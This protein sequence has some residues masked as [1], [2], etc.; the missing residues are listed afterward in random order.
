M[1]FSQKFAKINIMQKETKE[2][3]KKRIT[4]LF[5]STLLILF[6]ISLTIGGFFF[7]RSPSKQNQKEKITK[8]EAE[9][10]IKSLSPYLLLRETPQGK[11]IENTKEGISLKVP[12][13]WEVNEAISEQILEIRKFGPEQTIETELVDGTVLKLYA[14]ENPEGLSIKEIIMKNWGYIPKET[15]I[16]E[17]NG[18]EIAK[19]EDK[20]VIG[21]NNQKEED[22]IYK[23]DSKVLEITFVKDKKIYQ[24][25]CHA[26]G[27]QYNQYIQECE[28]LVKDKIKYE[29]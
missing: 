6:L 27:Q 1:I 23:E 5:L 2:I 28:N 22:V 11:I 4:F 12:E 29:F 10:T 24:F 21:L 18:I 19:T 15:L 26:A 20:I 7:F 8:E 25:S 3:E 17:F 16:E 13:G 9:E 14:K